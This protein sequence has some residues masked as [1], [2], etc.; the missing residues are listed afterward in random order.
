M[1]KSKWNAYHLAQAV[2]KNAPKGVNLLTLRKII[3]EYCGADERTIQKYLSLFKT[4][5]YLVEEN[6]LFK[7]NPNLHAMK[8]KSPKSLIE[9]WDF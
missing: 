8:P 4:T 1:N 3:Q 7:A 5:E 9:N 6:N 2:G